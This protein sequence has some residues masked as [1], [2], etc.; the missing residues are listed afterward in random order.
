MSFTLI[1]TRSIPMVSCRFMASASFS[2]VPTPSVPA[3]STG[4]RYRLGSSTSAPNPPMPASTSGRSVALANGLIA[5]TSASPASMSTPASR[6]DS[7]ELGEVMDLSRGGARCK[8]RGFTRILPEMT[9]ES[10][11]PGASPAPPS[12]E[13][14]ALA[15]SRRLRLPQYLWIV[16]AVLVI[17][18]LLHWLGAVLTPFL[19]AGIL[20]YFGNPAVNWGERHRVPRTAGTLLVIVLVLLLLLVLLLVLV[21][22]VQAEVALLMKRLPDLASQLYERVGPWL[23]QNLGI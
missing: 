3:T 15:V 20:A 23:A 16:G 2:L 12:P 6:Y 19:I 7:E 11:E 22:L 14:T 13:A 9:P 4:S 10:P 5:S 17:A 8:V 18:A 1:A 21:P